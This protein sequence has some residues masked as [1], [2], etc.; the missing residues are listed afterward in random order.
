MW[1]IEKVI[2]SRDLGPFFAP[3]SSFVV[4][5]FRLVNGTS[6]DTGC[7]LRDVAASSTARFAATRR[8]S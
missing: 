8:N 3:D 2:A 5:F 6:N 7:A 1:Q 4:S